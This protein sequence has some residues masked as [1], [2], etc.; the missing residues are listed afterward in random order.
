MS[1]DPLFKAYGSGL[2]PKRDLSIRYVEEKDIPAIAELFRLNYGDAYISRD[3]YDGTWVKHSIHSEQIICVVLESYGEVLATGSVI[4]NC[5]DYNDKC[6]ELARLVVHPAVTGRGLGSRMIDALFKIG[7]NTLEFAIGE[8]R[9]AHT[10]SQEMFEE[11]EF[12]LIGFFPLFGI[13]KGRRESAVLY[14]RLQGDGVQLRSTA[15]P[16]VITEVVPIA[17]TVLT[18]MGLKTELIEITDRV[19]PKESRNYSVRQ[20]DRASS[21]P[22]LRIPHGR[23]TNPLLFGNVSIEQGFTFIR[24]KARY[25]V[26]FDEQQNPVG[27]VGYQFDATNRL[28]RGI[29]LIAETEDVWPTLCRAL[30]Q[31]GKEH[32]AD[33]LSVDVSAYQP[34][35]Q[36]LLYNLGFRP[37]A[38]APAMVFHAT[39]RL[40]VIKM[41]K[42]NVP[43]EPG[44]L[45]LTEAAQKMVS[46]V[47]AAFRS[48][49]LK[50]R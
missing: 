42:L 20:I 8:C 13:C 35:L 44:E 22:L 3:V 12:P 32:G 24:D 47:E 21:G 40:D 39:E 5:G 41:I 28:I 49:P 4:L 36:R 30:I 1:M 14:A 48:T 50:Q 38:Y 16:R 7:S 6:G 23:I 37:A 2:Y 9:T 33:V 34:K 18:E 45:H 17:T 43:Y 25:V 11:A 29:E 19:L 31:A 10:V 27:T 26:A 46:L 15:P